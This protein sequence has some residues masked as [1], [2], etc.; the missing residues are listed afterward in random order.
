MRSTVFDQLDS[1]LSSEGQGVAYLPALVKGRLV[2]PPRIPVE[3]LASAEFNTVAQ[4][5]PGARQKP[6][7]FLLDGAQVI[8]LP[9]VDRSAL[10]PT[11]AEQFLVL[12]DLDPEVLIERDLSELAHSLYNL[13]FREVMDYVGALAQVLSAETEARRS[14]AL[15]AN[16]TSLTHDRAYNTV[17]ELLPRI[18]DP[19]SLADAVDRE[20]GDQDAPG[21]RYLDEWVPVRA[22]AHRGMTA[23]MADKISGAAEPPEY[24]HLQPRLRAMP[25]RQLHV[26]AGNSPLI[27]LLSLTRAFATKSA[28]VIKSPAEST[29]LSAFL[30][31]AMQAVDPRHPIT[32]HTSLLYWKGGDRRMEDT[33]LANGAFD[34]LVVWGATETI[35]SI[36]SRAG[37]TKSI[38]LNPRYALSFVG[39]E[40]FPGQVREVA[41][42]A[43]ADTMIANQ[44]ACISSLIHYVEGSEDEALEYCHALREVLSQWDRLLPHALSRSSLGQL[45]LLRRKEFLNGLW[46]EN[47]LWPQTT[48][49]VVYMPTEFDVA[50]HPMCRCVVVRRVNEM[51]DAL[52]FLHHSVAAVGIYPE[53]LR[54]GLRDEIASRGVSDILPLGEC[55]RVY[56]GMPHDGMRVLSELVNWVNG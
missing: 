11:G 16:A 34:R 3:R 37:F 18:L 23:R 38:F 42:R 43:A 21:T 15:Y 32:Q 12:P 2:F 9:L 44:M 29:L 10:T 33:L 13:P 24:A 26:T 35:N 50:A 46:F 8:R 54:D 41:M 7:W 56:A 36:K 55:E 31:L 19:Q 25:T 47:G 53:S 48:S 28:A 51:K 49:L 30:S 40:T 22:N 1:M 45:R 4:T 27:P 5:Q 52:P 39:R 6:S 20:L 14:A 17:F